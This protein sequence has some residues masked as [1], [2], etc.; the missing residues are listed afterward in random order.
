MT[1]K[2]KFDPIEYDLTIAKNMIN[3]TMSFIKRYQ[4]SAYQLGDSVYFEKREHM[5]TSKFKLNQ[6][7][8][9]L[10][11]VKDHMR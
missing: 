5:D 3:D 10:Q 7:I 8:E 11:R 9:Q 4:G 2:K 6:I 1:A